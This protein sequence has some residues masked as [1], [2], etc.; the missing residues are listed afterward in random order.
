VSVFGAVASVVWTRTLR[1]QLSWI[2]ELSLPLGKEL[3]QLSTNLELLNRELDRVLSV[4]SWG[5]P[6][7]RM[8]KLPE[9]AFNL[10]E[11]DLTRLEKSD[12]ADRF[13]W[14]S[15][16][17]EVRLRYVQVKVQ[18]AS[19][20][21]SLA[22]RDFD[23]ASNAYPKYEADMKGLIRFADSG[24]NRLDTQ[25]KDALLLAPRQIATLELSMKVLLAVIVVVSLLVLWLGEKTIEPLR[26]LRRGVR[27]LISGNLDLRDRASL[28]ALSLKGGDEA[29]DLAKDFLEVLT[30]LSEQ[31]RTL[32]FQNVRLEEQ[33]RLIVRVHENERWAQLGRMSAQVAH[34]VGNPLHSIG[35]EAELALQSLDSERVDI[36]GARQSLRSILDS[37]ERLREL[38]KHY[39]G[40]SRA[41]V[42]ASGVFD[43]I[44]SIERI[45]ATF[46][47]VVQASQVRLD[48]TIAEDARTT[49]IRGDEKH[50]EQALANLVA[51]AISASQSSAGSDQASSRFVRVELSRVRSEQL[52]IVVE[53]SGDGVPVEMREKIFEPFVTTKAQG[54]G[55]GLSFVKQVVQSMNG[56][57]QVSEGRN[58]GARFEWVLPEEVV[59]NAAV[60][61]DC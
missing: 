17:S 50:F 34:D 31:E 26:V 52:S 57:I 59:L 29:G 54:T 9:F 6:G 38:V 56:T 39:L 16:F 47:N 51:N 8:R 44:H 21:D 49:R 13:R 15:F 23:A 28:Q 19:I 36:H 7:F 20:A 55:L 25:T 32:E 1:Q 46:S 30:A 11:A 5:D 22:K 24:R 2:D 4:P 10:V 58:G 12:V 45:I 33:N 37:S 18:L 40:L 42:S 61:I 43:P 60:H 35:L 3:T 53:D 14:N 27:S 48:W 41:S